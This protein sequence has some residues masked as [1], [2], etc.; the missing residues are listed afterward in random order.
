MSNPLLPLVSVVIPAY[1]AERWISETLRSVQAQTYQN[2]EII[3]VDDD[4][5]DGLARIVRDMAADDARIRLVRKENGGVSAA[6]NT[7][8][9]EA[10]GDLIAPVDADD[11]WYPEKIEKQVGRFLA[12]KSGEGV[13]LGLVYCWSQSIDESGRATGPKLSRAVEEGMVYDELL[14]QNFT[15]NGSSA[16]MPKSLILELGGYPAWMTSGLEDWALYLRIAHDYPFG[17]VPEVLVGYRQL[18]SSMSR[19]LRFMLRGHRMMLDY[20]Q[21]CGIRVNPAVAK[22]QRLSLSIYALSRVTPVISFK[23]LRGLVEILRVD[24]FFCFRGFVAKTLFSIGY[25]KIRSSFGR[26]SIN[27]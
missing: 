6:R 7:G 1:N 14:M 17:V 9:E 20:L 8:I 12:A 13:R 18:E 24:P 10:R 11:I 22:H 3:V 16:M 15:S 4:S 23:F 19:S 27:G 2:L 5:P 26:K 21:G 25:G